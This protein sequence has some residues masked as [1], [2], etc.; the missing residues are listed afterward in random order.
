MA[1]ICGTTSSQALLTRPA[2]SSTRLTVEPEAETPPI[3][4]TLSTPA[5]EPDPELKAE[6]EKVKARATKPKSSRSVSAE[7]QGADAA[8][9][10][11]AEAS[12]TLPVARGNEFSDGIA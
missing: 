9:A 3:A 2:S 4:D 10:M 5:V 1:A 7:T 12:Q 11:P 8:P 6:V